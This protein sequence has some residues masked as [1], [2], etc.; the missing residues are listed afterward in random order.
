[1]SRSRT[2]RSM[3]WRSSGAAR[4][5]F[6]A[7]GRLSVPSVR[8]ATQTVPIPPRPSSRTRRYGPTSAPSRNCPVAEDSESAAALYFGR[9]SR[10]CSVA[11]RASAS[12]N[13]SM[14]GLYA[15]CVRTER[16]Q[17]SRPLLCREV[18]RFVEQRGD[19]SPV[20]CGDDNLRH[21]HLLT[22]SRDRGEQDRPRLQPMTLD[23]AG[24]HA[25]RFGHRTNR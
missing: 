18:E 14:V 25:E 24:R 9:L 12:S 15:A 8:R 6:S 2:N 11:A 1:M 7:T 20:L 23:G 10:K 13:A 19:V 5:I 4:R 17:P 3:N 16:L 22:A 21:R